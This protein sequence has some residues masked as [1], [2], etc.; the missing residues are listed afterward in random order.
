[1]REKLDPTNIVRGQLAPDP[2]APKCRPIL[3]TGP[4]VRAILNGTKTQTRRLVVPQPRGHLGYQMI[5]PGVATL[6]GPDYPDGDDDEIT[7]RHGVPGDRLWVR[8]KVL[9]CKGCSRPA[10]HED[11]TYVTFPDGGQVFRWDSGYI[12]WNGPP[13]KPETWPEWARWTPSIHMPRWASRITLEITEVRTQ[14]LQDIGW[15]DVKAEGVDISDVPARGWNRDVDCR[16]RFRQLWESIHGCESWEE[17]PWLW[18][19]SFRRV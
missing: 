18:A 1:M 10:T 9:L 8:E 5:G 19:I 4:M 7:C 11:A 2:C 16:H 17:N 15:R 14:R 6:C 13:P 12:P 3:F